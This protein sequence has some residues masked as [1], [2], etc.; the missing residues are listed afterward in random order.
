MY[1]LNVK[2]LSVEAD[3]D[4]WVVNCRFSQKGLYAYLDLD[5][6]SKDT[7]C[8]AG[9]VVEYLQERPHGRMSKRRK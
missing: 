1:L 6:P 5:K 8:R 2:F 7:A 3:A 4:A 9:E